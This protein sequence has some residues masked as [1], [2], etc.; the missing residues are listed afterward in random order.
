MQGLLYQMEVTALAVQLLPIPR[1]E[2]A[3]TDLAGLQRQPAACAAM[4]LGGQLV[5]QA[6]P[7]A[8]AAQIQAIVDHAHF[9]IGTAMGVLSGTVRRS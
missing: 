6:A 3:I 1:L 5:P 7:A 4:L 2:A 8:L 9:P